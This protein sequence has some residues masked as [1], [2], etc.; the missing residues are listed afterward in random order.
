MAIFFTLLLYYL[1]QTKTVGFQS[2]RRNGN[3]NAVTAFAKVSYPIASEGDAHKAGGNL[4]QLCAT[5][6]AARVTD[7][8]AARKIQLLWSADNRSQ[9]IIQDC[10]PNVLDELFRRLKLNEWFTIQLYD[11]TDALNFSFLS[12][13][14]WQV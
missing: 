9:R 14:I 12:F 2:E 6:L 7:E 4:V 3:E 13:I 10:A 8:E 11:N 1:K 5:D